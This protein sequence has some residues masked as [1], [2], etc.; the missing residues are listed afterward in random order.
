VSEIDLHTITTEELARE[1]AY[2]LEGTCQTM[3]QVADSLGVEDHLSEQ[4]FLLMIEDIVFCCAECA[5]W[6][7]LSEHY[8][9]DKRIICLECHREDNGGDDG[10]W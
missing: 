1:I 8:D 7:P 2:R 4:E 10:D 3:L 9:D 5:W 6:F